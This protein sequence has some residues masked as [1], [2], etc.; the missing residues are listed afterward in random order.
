MRPGLLLLLLL[1]CGDTPA[2]PTDVSIVSVSPPNAAV[3]VALETAITLELSEPP[4][5]DFAV[6]LAAET[7]EPIEH[8]VAVDGT[9]VTL[10]PAEPLW[11]ATGYTVTS[12]EF[13]ST[14]TTR[15]GAWRKVEL[16][17]EMM[18]AAAPLGSGS[19]PSIAVLSDGTAFAGWEGFGAIYDAR[20]TPGTGWPATPNRLAITGGDPDGVQLAAA[21]PVRAIA[22]HEKYV[23][24]RP[25]IDARTF[26]GTSWSAPVTVAPYLVGDTRYDQYL[27]GVAATNQTYALVWHRGDFDTAFD[28]Y[29]S[30]HT[31]SWSEPILVEKLE[32]SASGAQIID[33]GVGGY[34]IAWVQRSADNTA[35]AVWM[36]TLSSS[37]VVGVPQKLDDGAGSTWSLSAVRGGDTV[38]IAWA[39]QDGNIAFRVVAQPIRGGTAGARHEIAVDGFSFGGEWARIA[40][41]ARGAVVV[42]TQY[43]GVFAATLTGTTWSAVAELDQ[44][45]S[46]PNADVGRPAVALDDR[47]N[48]TVAWTRV[49]STGRRTTMFARARGGRWTAPEQL[50]EGTRSTYVWTTGVD[51]AGRVTTAW[52]QSDSNGYTVWSARLQ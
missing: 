51:A 1:A 19:A 35:S 25:N 18:S 2:S 44:I 34:V 38:W 43:G 22:G 7:G 31:G 36:T 46:D 27:G 33:D 39:H 50:D 21:S 6:A 47:G 41:S 14:F 24:T 23:V 11:I 13:A 48:A 5:A 16:H 10:T 29:A 42:Y 9:T 45:P 49:P 20:F 37:G 3:D 30:L 4:P 26:D 40:A 15:D 28:L 12:G 52:T 17:A 8:S 32:G